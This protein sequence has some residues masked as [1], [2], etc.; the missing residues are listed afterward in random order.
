MDISTIVQHIIKLITEN[1]LM[2]LLTICM[3]EIVKLFLPDSYEKKWI[4]ICAIAIA[5]ILG[6]LNHIKILDGWIGASLAVGIF[7]TGGYSLFFDWVEKFSMAVNKLL[8]KTKN[9]PNGKDKV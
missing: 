4:P 3:T 7:A 1:W 6:G 9:E 2:L 5:L 8:G